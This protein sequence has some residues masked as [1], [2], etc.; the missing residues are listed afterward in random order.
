MPLLPENKSLQKYYATLESR[1]G[2]KL[3]LGDTRH[4]GYY[5]SDT[6]WP[7][8]I[9]RHLRKMEEH[10]MRKLNLKE[11][12]LV[13][14]AGCGVGHVAMTG[15]QYGLRIC[16]IDVV[17]RH[18]KKARHNVRQA[19][20]ENRVELRKLDYHRLD[21]FKEC[22]F[23]GIYTMETFVHATD[24]RRALQEFFRVLKPGGKIALYEYDHK[25]RSESPADLQTSLDYVNLYAAMPA[26]A[27]FDEGV[28]EEMLQEVGFI[29]ITVT[30]LSINIRPMLRLFFIIAFIPY[31]IICFLGLQSWFVNTIAGYE[32][33]RGR[34]Y[35]RY[36]AVFANKPVII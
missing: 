28:L 1:I 19:G 30:D 13:L 29:D 23:D 25:P 9:T 22:S 36:I 20:L 24:P 10:L 5:E 8:P 35:W 4:F 12:A 34:R 18:L 15:A 11:G 27:V 17:D 26:N 32:S 7:F 16:G 2:Y 31:F 6:F 14:D 21:S 33:Y 3:L